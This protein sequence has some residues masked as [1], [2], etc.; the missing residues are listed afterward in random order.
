MKLSEPTEFGLPIIKCRRCGAQILVIANVGL[1]SKAIEAHVS[2]HKKKAKTR[3]AAEYDADV[4]RDEL[5]AMV[6]EK[7]SEL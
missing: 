4:V 7:T 5:I 6:L 3:K 1:M 2:E